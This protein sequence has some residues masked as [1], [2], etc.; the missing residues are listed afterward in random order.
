MLCDPLPFIIIRVWV[1]TLRLP[2][3]FHFIF[4]PHMAHTFALHFVFY[5]FYIF[6]VMVEEAW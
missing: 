2:G 5:H 6:D 1:T 3:H 4:T